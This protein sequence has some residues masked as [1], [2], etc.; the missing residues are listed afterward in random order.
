MD[1]ER[2]ISSAA[3][4]TESIMQAEA[5]TL[6]EDLSGTYWWYC[7]RREFILDVTSRFVPTSSRIIDYG[8][9]NGDIARGLQQTG[10]DIV[11]A[12]IA[13]K[14]LSA[15]R[16]AG[17]HTVDLRKD[18]LQQ[19]QAHCLLL[20][21]VLE[22][23]DDDVGILTHLRDT[24]CEAGHLIITVPAYEFLWSGEDFVSNHMR[25]YTCKRLTAAIREAD[26][27]VLWSSYFNFFLFPVIVTNILLKRILRPREM[28][29]SNVKPLAGW[30][31]SLL[32][33]VFQS[34]R[35]LLHFMRFPFGGSII[36]VARLRK[37]S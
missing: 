29:K 19:G 25:R 28:Y 16:V 30:L 37:T 20:A 1:N 32:Y 9:G 13:P 5:Y 6:M 2:V 7:A 14:S 24:L 10:Y 11:A 31:N 15:C 26:F 36:V 34:E 18:S 33:R 17:L 12:D 4:G 22:H 3:A 35:T 27:E 8:C 23:I 21:D